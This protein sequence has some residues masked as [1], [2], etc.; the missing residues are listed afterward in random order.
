ML[1]KYHS[2]IFILGIVLFFASCAK[3]GPTG[4]TG[5]PGPGYTG[6]VS[7]HA[8]LYD[9]YGSPVLVGLA[10]I[11]VTLAAVAP[12][13]PYVPDTAVHTDVNGN[14][15]YSNTVIT[16]TYSLSAIDSGYGTTVIGSFQY[17]SGTLNK[18][19]SMSAIPVFSVD[20]LIA[21]EDSVL[22]YDSLVIGVPADT[23]VRNCIVFV[24]SSAA[25]NLSYLLAYVVS[26]PANSTSVNLLIPAQDLRN[27]GI[28]HN[29]IAWYAAYSYVINDASVY[30]DYSTGVAKKV[31]NA[32]GVTPKTAFVIAP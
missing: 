5:L 32:V 24:N 10:N 18:D 6:T 9:Q 11:K 8:S 26:V 29:A 27:A 4:P 19:I 13:D 1:S 16:G 30:E 31:Y 7:V 3:E 12:L 23:R 2:V 28:P 21:F 14:Y 22:A 15:V 17:V 20:T 25:S